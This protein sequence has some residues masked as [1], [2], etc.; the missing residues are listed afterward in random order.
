MQILRNEVLLCRK[1]VS[2][3]AGSLRLRARRER[4]RL[5]FQIGNDPPLVFQDVFPLPFAADNRLAVFA[6][7]GTRLERLR[8]SARVLE[9]AV[10]RELDRGNALFDRRRFDAALAVFEA[11]TSYEAQF[12]A[13]LC[14][15]ELQRLDE[16][17]GHLQR[18]ADVRGDVWTALASWHLW[19]VRLR[20]NQRDQADLILLTLLSREQGREVALLVPDIL[21]QS[22]LKAYQERY[23]FSPAEALR[24]NPNRVANLERSLQLQELFQAHPHERYWTQAHLIIALE[25]AGQT[26]RALAMA[27]PFVEKVVADTTIDPVYQYDV[28]RGL[29]QLYLSHYKV[30]EA[31]DLVEKCLNT[32]T[33]AQEPVFSALR[34]ER[35]RI[36]ART[37]TKETEQA[38]RELE[39]FIRLASGGQYPPMLM[40]EAHLLRGY[41]RT[42]RGDEKGAREAWL[43]AYR[44]PNRD[45]LTIEGWIATALAGQMNAEELRR[46]V[47]RATRDSAATRSIVRLLQP[48]LPIADV[49]LVAREL[50]LS[51]WGKI[52]AQQYVFKYITISEFARK[53]PCLCIAETIRQ[54][55]CGGQFH[56]SQDSLVMKMAQDAVEAYAQNR[57]KVQHITGALLS[58][59]DKQEFERWADQL[60]PAI[61]GPFAYCLGLRYRRLKKPEQAEKLFRTAQALAPA[62]SLLDRLCRHELRPQP[63]R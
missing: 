16:A 10:P 43:A 4:D 20:L 59:Y 42:S 40:V 54:L 36:L 18:L 55:A 30:G 31:R 22:V 32:P 12:K 52:Y 25:V 17:A 56:P 53:F 34:V 41:L 13:A 1:Q 61:R 38:E 39:E 60:E 19:D 2:L 63:P 24:F 14:L 27:A 44:V 62:N 57:L 49:E 8:A 47:D 3:Q 5:S 37:S 48:L 11:L 9:P 51:P 23:A 6:S 35:A 7:P 58:W 28:I 21:R 26:D 46:M 50:W 29:V 33:K 45:P 15:I